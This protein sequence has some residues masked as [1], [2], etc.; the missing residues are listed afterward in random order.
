MKNM[1]LCLWMI[2]DLLPPQTLYTPNP[3]VL[4]NLWV[5]PW[6]KTIIKKKFEFFS[7]V[8]LEQYVE[9]VP[10]PSVDLEHCNSSSNYNGYLDASVVCTGARSDK[11]P[12]RVSFK[13]F[14]SFNR[15]LWSFQFY[16]V[17]MKKR[18]TK[19]WCYM[20]LGL[21]PFSQCFEDL[22]K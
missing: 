13:F 16:M 9:Y 10:D 2:F 7:V 14:L 6:H 15:L 17:N 20:Q 21:L 1:G 19:Y 3:N 4:R 8:N 18:P 11:N 22:D 5:A 12:C